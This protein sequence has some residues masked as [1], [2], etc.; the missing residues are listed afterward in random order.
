MKALIL[1]KFASLEGRDAY[2]QLCHLE[3][4]VDSFMVYGRYDAVLILQGKDLEE[5]HD[6]ILSE[7]Q[8]VPGVIE[9]MPCIIVEHDHPSPI[10]QKLQPLNR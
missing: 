4:V 5:V 8:P 2:S 1:I 9:I 6:T 3:S 7:I 10:N